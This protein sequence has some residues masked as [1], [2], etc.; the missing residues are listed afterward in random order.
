MI[1]GIGQEPFM[2]MWRSD[3]GRMIGAAKTGGAQV[4]LMTYPNYASPPVS[5]F[6]ALAETWSVPLVENHRSFTAL[7]DEGRAEEVLLRDL[8]HPNREGYAIV[9]RNVFELIIETGVLDQEIRKKTGP[10]G[11]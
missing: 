3:V 2:R 10:R 5:E 6:R 8:R 9:A 4:I 7:I 11:N 1:E